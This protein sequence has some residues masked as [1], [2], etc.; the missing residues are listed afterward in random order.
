[1]AQKAVTVGKMEGGQ[2]ESRQTSPAMASKMVC[3]QT[4]RDGKLPTLAPQ[5][6]LHCFTDP[7]GVGGLLPR[8][9]DL[10]WN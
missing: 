2:G 9:T 1:M 6:G 7:D 10:K 4:W 8:F 5:E 3:V